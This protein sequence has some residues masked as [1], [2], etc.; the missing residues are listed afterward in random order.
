MSN[1]SA[2][3]F[4]LGANSP[5]GFYSLYDSVMDP[6]EAEDVIILKGGPGGGK[7]LLLS[8]VAK[9]M[10]DAGA[11]MESLLRCDRPDT[12]DA[13]AFPELKTVLVD[14][15]APH[16]LEP[17][18]PAAV[19]RRVCLDEFYDTAALKERREEIISATLEYQSFLLQ[20]F[21]Y[22]SAARSV[23][24]DILHLLQTEETAARIA[25]RTAGIISRE[26]KKFRGRP[27]K[28]TR[29][30]LGGPTPDGVLCRF[31][32]VRVLCGRVYELVDSYG[33]ADSML[34]SLQN[35]A[36]ASGC[37]VIACPSPAAPERL[38][39][40]LIP[41]L[42]LAFVT[43]APVCP[44]DGEPFRRIRLDAV[45]DA[46]LFRRNKTRVRFAKKVSA[47]LLDEGV[48]CLAQARDRLDQLDSVYAPHVDRAGIAVLAERL[49][50]PLLEK[51]RGIQPL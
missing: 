16:V 3:R 11:K 38:S 12:P 14:G 28:V 29:R 34:L 25:R 51:Q 15:A 17:S 39:H 44:Y 49:S 13:L 30:F 18:Y 42:S 5:S 40:L 7:E 20:A 21:R 26:F 35:A 23:S 36:A 31:D 41:G 24:D 8:L 43:S 6:S 45:P 37:D 22:F 2:V 48:S 47:A 27:G 33:L 10:S 9:R 50:A 4:F 19:E 1:D 32:T 46:E